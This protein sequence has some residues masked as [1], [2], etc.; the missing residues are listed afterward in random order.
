MKNK[1]CKHNNEVD[2]V[3][4]ESS[5]VVNNSD[6]IEESNLVPSNELITKTKWYSELS[7]DKQKLIDKLTLIGDVKYIRS[8]DYIQEQIFN[9]ISEM[10]I[11]SLETHLN[12]ISNFDKKEEFLA[13]INFEFKKFEEKKDAFLITYS[14]KC[15]GRSCGNFGN[16]GKSFTGNISNTFFNVVVEKENNQCVGICKCYK[17]TVD[18]EILNK[19][20]LEADIEK[21][22]GYNFTDSDLDNLPF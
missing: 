3:L 22:N 16:N 5:I 8:E 19:T 11:Y 20:R 2:P 14:G 18:D 7:L 1:N 15:S 17:F 4:S 6:I 21:M 9:A 12:S 13:K 10:D